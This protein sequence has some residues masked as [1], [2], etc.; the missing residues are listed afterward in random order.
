MKLHSIVWEICILIAYMIISIAM[1]VQILYT[2]CKFYKFLVK[3]NV[4]VSWCV[5]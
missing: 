5:K 3:E 2:N 4:L 1:F